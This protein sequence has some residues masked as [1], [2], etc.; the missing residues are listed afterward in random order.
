MAHPDFHPKKR[1]G[2][3]FLID[4]NIV[5]KIIN[6]SELKKDDIVLEIGPGKGI[7]TRQLIQKSKKVIAVEVDKRLFRDLSE[8]YHGE[9]SIAL[10]NQ[11]ILKFDLKRALKTLKVKNKVKIIANIP[12]SITAPIIEYIFENIN[13]FSGVNLMVQKELSLRLVAK[14]GTDDYSSFS[15]FVQYY[16]NPRILFC[17]K[18]GCFRPQPRVDSCFIELR[19]KPYNEYMSVRERELLFKIIRTAFNQRRKTIVNSLSGLVEKKMF[20]QIIK[21]LHIDER[22]RAENLALRDYISISNE[23]MKRSKLDK[24]K[25]S[26]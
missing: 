7:L 16:T 6:F 24:H 11:D 10:F 2:Q 12:Y 26:F 3:S 21:K 19:P 13:L 9:D 25:D 23:M 17:V 8:T 22:F 1:F 4:M 14:P 15:C 5:R 18:R 20:L